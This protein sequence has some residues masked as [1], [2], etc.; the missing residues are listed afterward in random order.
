MAIFN[1]FHFY[2]YFSFHIFDNNSFRKKSLTLSRIN[3]SSKN[4]VSDPHVLSPPI[5]WQ[6]FQRA[7]LRYEI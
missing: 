1:D 5:L 7:V 6:K 3:F 4:T 2:Y